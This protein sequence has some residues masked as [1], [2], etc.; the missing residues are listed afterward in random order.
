MKKILAIALA[1][2]LIIG[3]AV[4]AHAVTPSLEVPDMP[5][6]SKIEFDIKIELPDDFWTRWFDEHPLT[7]YKLPSD[8]LQG[9][10][11]HLLRG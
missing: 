2:L 4:P 9:R 1:L 5:E 7:T 6:V 8:W 3:T 11:G 10:P